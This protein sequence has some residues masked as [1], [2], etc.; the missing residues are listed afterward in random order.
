[1]TTPPHGMH[2][3]TLCLTVKSSVAAIDFYKK[4]FDAQE[5]FKMTGPDGKSIMH[6][7]VKIGD[8]IIMLGDE[9]PQM[10]C[11]SPQSVGGPSSGVYLY[12]SDVDTIIK[13]AGANG[14]KILMSA[15]DAFW[16]DRMGSIEDPFGHRWT[17]A[18]HIKDM[19]KEEISKA[20]QEWMKS[21]CK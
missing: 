21:M 5:L 19:T 18:T 15:I 10:G 12:V 11:M 1:M 6:A 4:T 13:K 8:T 16:G 2:T 7:E 20:G 14:A 3:A 17:I 9:M